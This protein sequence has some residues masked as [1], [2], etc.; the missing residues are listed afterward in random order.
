MNGI[1]NFN[2]ISED[3]EEKKS[4]WGLSEKDIEKYNK[5]MGE[6]IQFDDKSI[7]DVNTE[8]PVVKERKSKKNWG[9][10]EKDIE[11]YNKLM[12]ENI[13]FD[14]KSTKDINSEAPMLD[15]RQ[16][17]IKL[18][19][20]FET[21]GFFKDTDKSDIK[22]ISNNEDR[23]SLDLDYLNKYQPNSQLEYNG[24]ICETDDNGEI[25]KKNGELLSNIEYISNGNTYKTDDKG[26]ITECDAHLNKITQEGER[27]QKDQL[28]VGGEERQ[29]DDDGGHII[30]RILGGAGGIENLVPMRKTINRGDYKKMENEIKEAIEDGK[31]VDVKVNVEYSDDNSKRPSKIEVK[32]TIDDKKT[33]EEFD[34]KENS[35]ELL[36]S[37]KD[38]ITEQD[39]KNLKQEIE[40]IKEDG[41]QVTITSVKTEYDENGNQTKVTVGV[42]DETTGRKTYKVYNSK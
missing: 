32:Y 18:D 11:K 23:K 21:G 6:N 28:D 4:N 7:K 37:L 1:G 2:E 38:K 5:L 24:D 35:T 17:K 20:L 30:A 29:E 41:G 16:I 40:D 14:D 3:L 12:G 27:N 33:V 25:Y 8:A 34:N 42:L 36:D 39:Y 10:N 26:R 15:G 9:L 22:D 31:P 19:S 13:Q